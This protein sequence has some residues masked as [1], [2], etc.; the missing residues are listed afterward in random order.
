MTPEQKDRYRGMD[1]VGQEDGDIN[2]DG[3]KDGTDKYLANRRRRLVK[4][5]RRNVV[6]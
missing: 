1:P 4:Q 2:N 3:K 6:V 5:L